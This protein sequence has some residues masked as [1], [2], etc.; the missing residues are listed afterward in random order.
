MS[1]KCS[2]DQFELGIPIFFAPHTSQL[3]MAVLSPEVLSSKFPQ[4]VQKTRD[5]IA[6]IVAINL[7]SVLLDSKCRAQTA[8]I[9]YDITERQGRRSIGSHS[10]GGKKLGPPSK[11]T[12]AA[13][14]GK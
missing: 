14:S 12:G 6:A 2:D 11:S 5:P 9:A 10:I 13:A 4:S 3:S 8:V 7:D 1:F